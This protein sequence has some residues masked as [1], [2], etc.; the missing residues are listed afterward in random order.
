[1]NHRS[2]KCN[3]INS[4]VEK[5]RMEFISAQTQNQFKIEPSKLNTSGG[6]YMSGQDIAF[7]ST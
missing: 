3:Y 7:E 1:M 4:R 6:A 2:Y 5:D